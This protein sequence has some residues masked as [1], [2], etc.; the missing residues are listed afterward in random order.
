MSVA[1]QDEAEQS[2]SALFHIPSASALDSLDLEEDPCR[3]PDP[4]DE[5][6]RERIDELDYGHL[7][8]GW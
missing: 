3:G 6:A 1:D 8:T 5:W 4:I 7:N 2:T